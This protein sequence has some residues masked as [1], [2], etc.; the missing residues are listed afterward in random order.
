MLWGANI[1]KR[2]PSLDAVLLAGLG[3]DLPRDMNDLLR[4]ML[5]AAYAQRP[6]CQAIIETLASREQGPPSPHLPLK[7]GA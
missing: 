2:F 5:N 1:T 7:L 6:R 3:A 4:A